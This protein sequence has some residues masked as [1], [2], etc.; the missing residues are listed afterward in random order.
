[1]K[2]NPRNVNFVHPTAFTNG[3]PFGAGDYAGTEFAYVEAGVLTPCI[4]V[5]V[6][7]GDGT[8]SVPLSELALP[9][10]TELTLVA[11]T[12]AANGTSSEWSAPSD[13]FMFDVRVP[14]APGVSVD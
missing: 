6:S 5:P 11:R 4:S 7:F 9:L 3:E 10:N 8:G 12:V 2:Y 13:P 14:N 1:M